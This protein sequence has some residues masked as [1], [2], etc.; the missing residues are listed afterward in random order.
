MLDQI[1]KLFGIT[2]HVD[3]DLMQSGQPLAG[4]TARIVD[5]LTPVIAGLQP[6]AILVLG[7]TTTTFCSVL[8]AFYQD[9]PIGHVEA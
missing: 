9:V 3:L 2:P 7:D 6:D 8:A 4:L 1:L 5:R